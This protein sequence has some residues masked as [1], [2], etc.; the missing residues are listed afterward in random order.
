VSPADL[1]RQSGSDCSRSGSRLAFS[2]GVKPVHILHLGD[3]ALTIY[4]SHQ[5]PPNARKL[6]TNER[7]ASVST[8]LRRSRA[9]RY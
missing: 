8:W 2:D 7:A 3:A 4:T 9:L 1:P 5:P 6:A